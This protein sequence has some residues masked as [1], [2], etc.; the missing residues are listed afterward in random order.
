MKI[1][2]NFEL[3][4][5]DDHQTFLKKHQRDIADARPDI[6]HQILLTLLDSPLNKAGLLQVYIHTAK[7]VLIEVSPHT[8]IPRTFKRFCG[9]MGTACPAARLGDDVHICVGFPCVCAR[10]R[11]WLEVDT[12][13]DG[14][15]F[16]SS[17]S[18]CACVRVSRCIVQLLHKLSI[19]ATN[20]PDK[21]L[22]VI[23]NPITD[24]LPPNVKKI[25]MSV[26]VVAVVVV[27][28]LL[29]RALAPG[30]GRHNETGECRVRGWVV[31][32]MVSLCVLL[33]G[34]TT[35]DVAV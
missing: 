26:V 5:C 25:G 24:H 3:L 1:G 31:V 19:R 23:K 20:G 8:R 29:R 7:G 28:H 9:L 10:A 32:L 4:N 12:G 13:V 34:W 22:K 16:L 15:F 17:M 2:K 35:T 21:L 30:R 11:V 33:A 6:T 14:G 27:V 18:V